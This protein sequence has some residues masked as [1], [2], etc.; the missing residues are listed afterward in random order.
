MEFSHRFY[1]CRCYLLILSLLTFFQPIA[2]NNASTQ[3]MQPVSNPF[4]SNDQKNKME[5]Q[6]Q[7]TQ[8]IQKQSAAK[9]SGIILVPQCTSADMEKFKNDRFVL[10]E[11]PTC[12]PPIE[13][14][15]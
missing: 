1:T 11:I 10:G 15:G 7:M 5:G 2:T 9:T 14:C 3:Q 6:K 4:L 8:Q 12:P 13:L